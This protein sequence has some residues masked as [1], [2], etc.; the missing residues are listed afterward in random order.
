MKV[1][2]ITPLERDEL[3][4][5]RYDLYLLEATETI[6]VFQVIRSLGDYPTYGL[7]KAWA[8]TYRDRFYQESVVIPWV[9]PGTTLSNLVATR[10]L[11]GD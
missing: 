10:L 3:D 5:R 9:Q 8:N 1:I 4:Q 6:P 11:Y 2:G 7:A